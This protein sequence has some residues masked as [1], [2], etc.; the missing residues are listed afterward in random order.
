M[1]REWTWMEVERMERWS[2]CEVARVWWLGL[3]GKMMTVRLL[4]FFLSLLTRIY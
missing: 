3:V 1:V 2:E 4:V